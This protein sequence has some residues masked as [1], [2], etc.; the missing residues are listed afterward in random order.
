MVKSGGGGTFQLGSKPPSAMARQHD[1]CLWRVYEVKSRFFNNFEDSN[2]SLSQCTAVRYSKVKAPFC[3]Q[4]CVRP[5][6]GSNYERPFYSLSSSI[7]TSCYFI[8]R[9]RHLSEVTIEL[10]FYR[11]AFL[12]QNLH[13]WIS[14][15]RPNGLLLNMSGFITLKLALSWTNQNIC[16]NCDG[17]ILLLKGAL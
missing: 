8:L 16:H 13:I 1:K 7:S 15:K 6:V 11:K 4:S 2:C 9:F 12:D 10:F 5:V 17:D 3:V 14:H